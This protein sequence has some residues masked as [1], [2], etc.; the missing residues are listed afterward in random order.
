MSAQQPAS[1]LTEAAALLHTVLA[2]AETIRTLSNA[3]TVGQQPTVATS[4][5]SRDTLDS[6]IA[7]LFPSGQHSTVTLPTAAPVRREC[8][9]RYQAQRFSSWTSATRRKRVRTQQHD[10]F[11]K[12]VILLPNQSWGVVC[13]QGPKSWLHKHGHIL[14]AFELQK[15]WDHQTVL[16]RIRDGFGEN[17]PDDVSLQF[18]M[19][20]GN[21]LVF[22]KLQD[23]QELNGMLIHKVFKTKALYVRPSRTLLIRTDMSSN[24]TTRAAT[25]FRAMKSNEYPSTSSHDGEGKPGTSTGHED[26]Y[27]PNHTVSSSGHDGGC[28][29][30]GDG[31]AGTSGDDGG[32]LANGNGN[33]GTSGTTT[34]HVGDYASYLTLVATL[35]PDSSDDEE[36]NQA[37][38]ASMEIQI[39]EKV[40][41]Q[42]ILLELSSKIST[43]R[44][45]KFN[46]NRSAVWEGAMRGFQRVSYDP[47]LMICVKFSDDMG[48]NEEGVDLGGPRREFLR[49]L[50][51]TIA[52]SPMFEGKENSKN[53]AL[54]STALREDWYYIAGK[55]IAVSL[56]HGG[57]PPNFLSP[58]VFCLLVN[59][60]VNPKLEDI[61][62]TELLEKVKKVSESTTLEDLEKSNAPL[63]DYLANAGCLRPMRSIRD[64]D[65]LVQDIVMFQVIH[66]VQSPFQ[67]FCEGLKT[68]GVLDQ[69]RRHPDSFRPLFCYEP[70]T[71]TA[72]QMIFSAFVSLQKGA[73][74]ELLRRWSLLSGGTISKMQKFIHKGDDGFS[75][76]MFPLA[77]TCVN[78]IKLPLH[79]SYQLF[80]EKF[81]FALGNTYG[82]G[83]A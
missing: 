56:V 34:D 79:V 13:K 54:D 72:D 14:S 8:A 69:V 62:D 51:E 30:R 60:S 2:S 73:T 5:S 31:S 17:I 10:H 65:L 53:L 58:T 19:A 16:E 7:S 55:A 28:L 59:G 22:P 50:M 21:K 1:S 77:N 26:S 49:L 48:R 32:Y 11:N 37:I 46:I 64:R 47:N 75:T 25:R 18:L 67:R 12:D 45:C 33:P 15:D 6:H 39:A 70:N 43:K 20:C 42:E 35:P 41:V 80:K 44:Q 63:L 29:A 27:G 9:P 38:F 57:P 40:P 68:L 82:F 66:R 36:L 61:A 83:R 23:G 24:G 71:L 81:D 3:T 4:S 76:S 78:C 52:R 74:R